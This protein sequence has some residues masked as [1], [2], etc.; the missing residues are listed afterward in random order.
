MTVLDPADAVELDRLLRQA[1]EADV[2]GVLRG[3]TDGADMEQAAIDTIAAHCRVDHVATLV[4]PAAVDDVHTHLLGCQ[5]RTTSEV[6]SVVVRRRLAHRYGLDDELLDVSIIRAFAHDTAG[7]E[8]FCLPPTVATKHVVECERRLHQERH[9]ALM[10]DTPSRSLLSELRS[11]LTGQL[12]MRPDGGGHN[13]HE[14][15]EAG[16]RS[17]LYFQPPVGNRLELTCIGDFTP[18]V[19][20]HLDGA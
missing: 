20:Q 7:V 10:V 15:Q 4:F 9:T 2:P 8:V 12:A 18:V 19:A 17:V 6:P 14:N 3:M 5:W 13:P 16:G 11:L 1:A